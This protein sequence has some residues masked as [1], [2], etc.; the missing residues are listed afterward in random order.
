MSIFEEYKVGEDCV[1]TAMVVSLQ[2]RFT[3]N[4]NTYY[5]ATLS[6]GNINVDARI[7]KC[8]LIEDANIKEG[9][10]CNISAHINNYNDKLQYVIKQIALCETADQSEFVKKAPVEEK[11][12]RIKIKEYINKINNKKFLSI[13]N[14][15]LMENDEAYYTYPAAMSMHHGYKCGLVYHTY[16][17]LKLADTIISN[18]PG[19]NSDLLYTGIILHDIGKTKELSGV[20]NP[21]Y[22]KEGNLL[23][24]IVIGLQMIA[25]AAKELN[26]ENTEEIDMLEH[27]IASHHGELEYGSPKTPLT[28]EA[29]ALHNIDLIDAKLA[30]LSVEVVKTE[31]GS[32]TGQ[33]NSINRKSLY[34]PNIE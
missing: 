3:S 6:D 17:M 4:E 2:K 28:M 10:V 26:I 14:K 5:C 1:F 29:W 25:V 9:D 7:W 34:V 32:Q 23:G 33:I 20:N 22:T 8:S 13:I 27:L 24:H 19:I 31:K 12:L 16:S 18:Y 21:V 30:S 11:E 15:L